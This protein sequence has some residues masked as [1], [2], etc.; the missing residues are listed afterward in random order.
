MHDTALMYGQYFFFT[1]LRDATGL[2]I[3]DIG[4]QDINGSLRAVAPLKTII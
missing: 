3:V 4:A 2:K 1:Y